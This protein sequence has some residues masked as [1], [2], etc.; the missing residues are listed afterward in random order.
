[1][2]ALVLPQSLSLGQLS[3]ISAT[4]AGE[5]IDGGNSD[6]AKQ[7]LGAT[8]AS[9]AS[10]AAFAP[11]PDARRSLLASDASQAATLREGGLKLE[12]GQHYLSCINLFMYIY[13][14][15]HMRVYYITSKSRYYDDQSN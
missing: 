11:V 5:A 8:T 14:S 3:N 9:I 2:A 10:S 7:V 13:T 1:M 6:A 15:K 12:F 4:K